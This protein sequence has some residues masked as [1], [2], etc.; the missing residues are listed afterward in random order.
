VLTIVDLTN[1]LNRSGSLHPS[2]LLAVSGDTLPAKLDGMCKQ[3]FAS[4]L[5]VLLHVLNFLAFCYLRTESIEH[6]VIYVMLIRRLS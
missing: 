1:S 4:E 6:S 2:P 3:S 5:D